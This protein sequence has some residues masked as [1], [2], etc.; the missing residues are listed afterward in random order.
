MKIIETQTASTTNQLKMQLNIPST[1]GQKP[2]KRQTS[3]PS[4]LK[5]DCSP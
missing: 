2:N 1:V 4:L 5:R 3:N